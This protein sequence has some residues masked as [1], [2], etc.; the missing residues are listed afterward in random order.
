MLFNA[1]CELTKF[2]SVRNEFASV[3][4]EFEIGFGRDWV[5]D[6]STR[7]SFHPHR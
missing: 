1:V 6:N 7:P 2:S 5:P 3:G 4:N